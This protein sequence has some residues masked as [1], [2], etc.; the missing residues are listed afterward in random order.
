MR[1]NDHRHLVLQ[2]AKADQS[3]EGLRDK[4]KVLFKAPLLL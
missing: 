4:L 3:V 2:Y 1:A